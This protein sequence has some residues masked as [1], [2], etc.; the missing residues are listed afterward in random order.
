MRISPREVKLAFLLNDET[1][2]KIAAYESSRWAASVTENDVKQLWKRFIDE[3]LSCVDKQ[4]FTEKEMLLLTSYLT[5]KDTLQ[6]LESLDRLTSD[7]LKRFLVLVQWYAS[8]NASNSFTVHSKQF[9]DRVI[10]TYR[11]YMLPKVFSEE[12]LR[13]AINLIK[14][15]H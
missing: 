15:T 9:I 5:T 12:R 11:M 1:K 6:L 10:I 14:S 4:V 13:E 8:S 7:M 3:L 2:S